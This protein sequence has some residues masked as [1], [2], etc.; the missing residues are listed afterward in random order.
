MRGPARL[1]RAAMKSRHPIQRRWMGSGDWSAHNVPTVQPAQKSSPA[2]GRGIILRLRVSMFPLGTMSSGNSSARTASSPRCAPVSA[3]SEPSGGARSPHSPVLSDVAISPAHEARLPIK[4]PAVASHR[5]FSLLSQ[6]WS[7]CAT[8]RRPMRYARPHRQ[9]T[10]KR[11]PPREDLARK[12]T[13]A[14]P[15][16]CTGYGQPIAPGPAHS[17]PSQRILVFPLTRTSRHA[18]ERM[19]SGSDPPS[20]DEK[21]EFWPSS[22]SAC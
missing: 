12:H 16:V 7:P 4:G 11:L 22:A 15:Y 19:V 14:S 10:H 20:R 13:R 17:H 6:T 18:H 5:F 2:R 1:H 3:E 9:D 8:R 21:P